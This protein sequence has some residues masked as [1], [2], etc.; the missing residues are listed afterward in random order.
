MAVEL[1]WQDGIVVQSSVRPSAGLTSDWTTKAWGCVITLN[2]EDE[3][4]KNQVPAD[5]ENLT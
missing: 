5:R 2:A 4:N 1:G 3:M